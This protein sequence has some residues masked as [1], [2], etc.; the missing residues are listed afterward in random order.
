MNE[1][2]AGCGQRVPDGDLH[3]ELYCKLYREGVR[4]DEAETFLRGSGF[5]RAGSLKN[6]TVNLA[7][8]AT[9]LVGG[10]LVLAP[11]VWIVVTVYRAI[12]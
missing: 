4:H 2:C 10:A 9:M 11:F 3:P 8:A 7:T 5:V 12:L 1:R 6:G